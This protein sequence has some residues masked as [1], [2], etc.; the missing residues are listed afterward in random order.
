MF[1]SKFLRGTVYP[2]AVFAGGMVGVGFFSLPYL[3]A[4]TNIWLMLGYFIV[5]TYLVVMINLMFAEVSLKT[6]DF[7]R[8]PGFARYHLGRWGEYVA[9]L[10]TILG[11][12]GVLLACL[13]V[14]SKFFHAVFQPIFGG[15]LLAYMLLY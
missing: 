13:I 4:Q 1:N 9:M 7:K 6:P 12:F 8:F 14:G 3:A 5:L 11:S 15:T 2:V 10:F